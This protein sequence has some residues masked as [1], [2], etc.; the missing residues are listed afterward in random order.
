MSAPTAA[1]KP[2]EAWGLMDLIL[3]P[4]P[5]EDAEVDAILSAPDLEPGLR[6]V[7]TAAF[8]LARLVD[9]VAAEAAGVRSAASVLCYADLLLDETGGRAF[10]GVLM[11]CI[12]T[13]RTAVTAEQLRCAHLSYRQLFGQAPAGG[14]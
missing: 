11:D 4:V 10:A 7:L 13:G 5:G 12:T 2:A 3:E 1:P 6:E 9:P 8:T 14:A